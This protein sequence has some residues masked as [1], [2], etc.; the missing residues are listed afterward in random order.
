MSYGPASI[1]PITSALRFRVRPELGGG[2]RRSTDD[3]SSKRALGGSNSAPVL[4]MTGGKHL[5][6]PKGTE[7][8]CVI[9]RFVLNPHH[10]NDRP[11]RRIRQLTDLGSLIFSARAGCHAGLAGDFTKI[12]V[13][14]VM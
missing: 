8:R 13:R 3:R 12:T 6:T 5:R 10:N 4:V 7:V 14:T 1:W 2:G 11:N 9:M